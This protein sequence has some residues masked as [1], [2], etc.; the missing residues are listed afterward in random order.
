MRT[1]LLL[2]I[3]TAIGMVRTG[4]AQEAYAVFNDSTLT[5]YYDSQKENREGKVF[6]SFDPDYENSSMAK[7]AGPF[8]TINTEINTVVFD[9]SFVDYRPPHTV[10]WFEC[11]YNLRTISGISNLNTEEVTEMSRMFRCCWNITTLDLS[12]FNTEK[13]T[14][15]SLMFSNC[16]SLTNID[17]S[18]FDTKDVIDMDDMFA[19]CRNITTLD[20][21]NFDTENVKYM[22]RM[23]NDCCVLTTIYVGNGWSTYS[24]EE[25]G[26]MFYNCVNLIGGK[27]SVYSLYR[28]DY[29]FAHI[30]EGEEN[31]GYFT[32]REKTGVNNVFGTNEAKEST[33]IYT[34][35]RRKV[36]VQRNKLS[37][38]IYIIG[39]KKV[40]M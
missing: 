23:F 26:F 35:D 2:L 3:V 12:S 22:V 15:M 8:C 7:G 24:V 1:R 25:G 17:L 20:L 13:V 27:G 30:D 9:D 39:G 33:D 5:F 14:D 16:N 40:I 37:H 38:G 11:C 36:S 34:I 31:P 6:E 19:D 4:V 32:Y 21:S 18:S 28:T 10:R 29:K